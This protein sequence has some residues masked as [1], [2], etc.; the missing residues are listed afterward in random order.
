MYA[1]TFDTQE[2]R[3]MCPLPD[4]TQVKE[5]NQV[6]GLSPLAGATPFIQSVCSTILL[7]PT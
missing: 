3:S 7:S 1:N 4:K 2:F 5:F 6:S